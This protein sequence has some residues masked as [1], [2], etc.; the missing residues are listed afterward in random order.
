MNF[1]KKEL[2]SNSTD[3][4]LYTNSVNQSHKLMLGEYKLTS[5][6][7]GTKYEIYMT[8]TNSLG[9]GEA[10]ERIFGK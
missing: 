7:C 1:S 2:Q 4:N 5:L 8:A 9:T 10:S 3:L 6:R